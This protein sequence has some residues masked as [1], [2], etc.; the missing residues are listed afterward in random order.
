MRRALT[1]WRRGDW[2]SAA[3]V[4]VAPSRRLGLTGNVP[5]R[6]SA[7]SGSTSCP[8]SSDRGGRVERG[9]TPCTR[10]SASRD[11]RPARTMRPAQLAVVTHV[12]CHSAQSRL[13]V[14]AAIAGG[15]AK[16]ENHRK[17]QIEKQSGNPAELARSLITAKIRRRALHRRRGCVLRSKR[18]PSCATSISAVARH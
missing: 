18:S 2:C 16:P 12:R 13:L 9:Q 1:F 4:R 5:S 3:C 14:S 11:C 8:S 7:I 10:G 6:L 15:R 17:V